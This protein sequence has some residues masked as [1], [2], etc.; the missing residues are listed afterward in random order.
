M[1]SFNM[2]TVLNH[3]EVMVQGISRQPLH[4]LPPLKSQKEVREE[5]SGGSL[6]QHHASVGM[7]FYLREYGELHGSEEM[8][9]LCKA[10]YIEKCI[11]LGTPYYVGEFWARKEWC[12][13]SLICQKN[14]NCSKKQIYPGGRL[15]SRAPRH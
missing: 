15:S 12:P 3:H 1:H 8:P 7:N 11:S 2:R 13:N 9:R 14:K 4:L 5:Y 10:S 6:G